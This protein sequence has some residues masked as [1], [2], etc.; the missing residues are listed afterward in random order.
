MNRVIRVIPLKSASGYTMY[1]G[2]MPGNRK[3]STLMC[4]PHETVEECDNKLSRLVVQGI[5]KE[6]VTQV[7]TGHGYEENDKNYLMPMDASPSQSVNE[8][9]AA[10]ILN[11]INKQQFS[12][13]LKKSS[14]RTTTST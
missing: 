1:P 13:S 10:Q 4:A 11:L 12:T 14:Y 6:N 2:N 5:I 8:C 9:I 7:E 3:T